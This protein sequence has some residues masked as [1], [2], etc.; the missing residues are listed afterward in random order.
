MALMLAL[1]GAAV[2]GALVLNAGDKVGLVAAARD[3]EPGTVISKEDLRRADG[4]LDGVAAVRA[5]D[6]ASLLGQTAVGPIPAGTLIAPGMVTRDAAPQAG[7]VAVGLAL[8]PGAL[9]TRE[10]VARR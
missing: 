9:P 2:S 3:I 6:A 8:R 4:S 10:L 1:G 5:Q 7:R